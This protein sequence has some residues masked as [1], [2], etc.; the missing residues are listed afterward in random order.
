M[1]LKTDYSHFSIMDFEVRI[2]EVKTVPKK[3]RELVKQVAESD[4]KLHIIEEAPKEKKAPLRRPKVKKG[5][6]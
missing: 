6:K 5:K 3:L 1:K 4:P 2:G